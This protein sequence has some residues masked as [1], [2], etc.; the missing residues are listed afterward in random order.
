MADDPKKTAEDE[1]KAAEKA[2][3]DALH[4]QDN[5]VTP[6]PTQAENDAAKT[7]AQAGGVPTDDEGAD[8]RRAK[9]AEAKAVSPGEYKNR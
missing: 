9:A 3:A 4:A 5:P 6:S 1:K 7:Q 2:R 8:A